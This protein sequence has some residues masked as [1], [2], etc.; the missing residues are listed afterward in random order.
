VNEAW[1]VLGDFNAIRK[2]K[3]M[4]GVNEID[5]GMREITDYSKFIEEMELVDILMVD[6][7]YTWY[8]VSGANYEQK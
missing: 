6:K 5:R 2:P 7:R 1:C 4:R 8:N 3:E